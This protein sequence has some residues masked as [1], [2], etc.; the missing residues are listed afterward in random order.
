MSISCNYC[1]AVAGKG[2]H[3]GHRVGCPSLKPEPWRY[4]KGCWCPLEECQPLWKDKRK[5]C[6]DCSHTP[7]QPKDGFSRV[8]DEQKASRNP[9]SL[10]RVCVYCKTVAVKENGV[11]RHLYLKQ[12]G[13][14]H[15]ATVKIAVSSN[16]ES[17]STE[18]QTKALIATYEKK[19]VRA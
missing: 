2:F 7:T 14:D 8:F 9:E 6:P 19:K 4:C 5:C 12:G 11:W 16:P 3:L 13:Y 1:G 17:L 10:T 15:E 18:C